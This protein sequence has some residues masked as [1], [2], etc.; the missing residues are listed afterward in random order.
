VVSWTELAIFSCGVVSYTA[1]VGPNILVWGGKSQIVIMEIKA[2]RILSRTL[3]SCDPGYYAWD[4]VV[5]TLS[6]GVKSLSVTIQMKATEQ[7]SPVVLFA[8]P[9]TV[10][11]SRSP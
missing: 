5:L 10:V 3:N 11:T 8:M 7:F 6:L 4:M 9:Q 2:I 1:L